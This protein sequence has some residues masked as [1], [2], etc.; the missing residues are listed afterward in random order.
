[1]I[2][3]LGLDYA[4]LKLFELSILWRAGVSTLPFFSRVDLGVHEEVLRLQLYNPDPGPPDRFGAIMF[5]L[6]V[7]E[8]AQ[9]L[10]VIAE[11][12]PMRSFGLRAYNF[13]FGGFLWVFHVSS[14]DPPPL[15][16][17]AFLRENGSRM[18]SVRNALEMQNLHAFAYAL[19]RLGRA[20]RLRPTPP[21]SS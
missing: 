15:A 1:M 16:R 10:Q 21:A 8:T 3:V 4:K 5:G 13:T 18:I 17:L 14:I 2:Q 9:T 7:G 20:P 6:K 19:N 11:P 12:R